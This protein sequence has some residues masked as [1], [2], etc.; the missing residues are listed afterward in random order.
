[1]FAIRAPGASPWLL[2]QLAYAVFHR[3]ERAE[4]VAR[5]ILPKPIAYSVCRKGSRLAHLYGLPKTHKQQLSMRPIL[6][7]TGTYNHGLAKWLEEKLKPFSLNRHTIS[8]TFSFA[9]EIS[10]KRHSTRMTSSCLMTFL[11]YSSTCHLMEQL[12]S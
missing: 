10:R 3:I 2:R 11:P 6:S 9:E 1:M 12:R 4:S 7:S 5:K 8:D